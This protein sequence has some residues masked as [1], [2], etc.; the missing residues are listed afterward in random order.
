MKKIRFEINICGMSDKTYS[1][2]ILI[3]K[4]YAQIKKTFY[5]GKENYHSLTI[6]D[7]VDR[8]KS[9][10]VATRITKYFDINTVTLDNLYIKSKGSLLKFQYDRPVSEVFEYFKT[11]KLDLVI[12]FIGGG[13][14]RNYEGYRL[15]VFPNEQIH[16]YTPHVHVIK[17]N[18]KVRYYLE[19]LERFPKD[20]CPREFLRDEKKIIIPAIKMHRDELMRKWDE[21]IN[22]YIPPQTDLKGKGY[23]AET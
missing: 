7:C 22:G 3:D 17:D 8:L 23:Y 11:R 16:R 5:I 19:T 20:K 6:G 15:A 2:K 4:P 18:H 14:S 10:R 1:E 13:A 12:F 21:Y 9:H